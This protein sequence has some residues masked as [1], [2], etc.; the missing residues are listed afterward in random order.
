MRE[1]VTKS[2][3]SRKDEMLLESHEF[4][5]IIHPLQDYLKSRRSSIQSKSIDG[6]ASLG[7]TLHNDSTLVPVKFPNADLAS[8]KEIGDSGDGSESGS[9]LGD[10]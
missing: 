8:D 1:K 7:A 4:G 3:D 5:H 9:D 10:G 2:F 6:N